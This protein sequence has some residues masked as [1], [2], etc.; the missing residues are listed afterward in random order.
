LEDSTRV[1]NGIYLNLPARVVLN[2]LQLGLR[3][4]EHDSI[5]LKLRF[6]FHADQT[7]GNWDPL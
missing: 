4:D 5:G 3:L 7:R 6:V 1:K 2:R